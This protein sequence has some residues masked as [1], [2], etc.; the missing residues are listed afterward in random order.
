MVFSIFPQTEACIH[1]LLNPWYW[2]WK[3]WTDCIWLKHL[4]E[5][6]E[7][8]LMEC[9]NQRLF[10]NLF[11]FTLMASLHFRRN[12]FN[13]P[14]VWLLEIKCVL[15]TTRLEKQHEGKQNR[16]TWIESE[17][18]THEVI[19]PNIYWICLI[20]YSWRLQCCFGDSF[21]RRRFH[22]LIHN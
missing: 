9:R 4:N 6:N 16:L 1:S 17:T 15:Y 20:S 19:L 12:G 10:C 5:K 14:I 8:I 18:K 22:P 13:S 3:E 11:R 21:C 7:R 2:L